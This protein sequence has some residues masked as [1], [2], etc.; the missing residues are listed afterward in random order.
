MMVLIHTTIVLCILVTVETIVS[1]KINP[2]AKLHY[3]P[4]DIQKRVS[5]LEEYQGKGRGSLSKKERIVKM[6]PALVLLLFVIA[7][8][9]HLAGADH[10]WEGFGYT[11]AI[12][13]VIK[14]YMALVLF[15][16]WYAHSPSAWIGG[17][18]DMKASYQNYRFYLRSVPRS[19]PLG[20]VVATMIGIMIALL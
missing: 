16:G 14:W 12:W 2:L 4:M 5:S 8:L 19:F 1:V 18:Q 20:A 7:A 9:V 6:I 15:C 13:F 11:F 3:L 17:T 10:F